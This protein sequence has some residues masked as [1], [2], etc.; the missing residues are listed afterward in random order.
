LYLYLLET[1]TMPQT[2]SV[3]AIW[4]LH[5][6]IIYIYISD[7]PYLVSPISNQ[8]RS[9]YESLNKRGSLYGCGKRLV[10]GQP[11]YMCSRLNRSL[12][13]TFLAS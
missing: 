10:L 2:Q 1:E 11:V 9:V 7:L 5:M 4:N 3:I 13:S 8:I 12:F 6:Y